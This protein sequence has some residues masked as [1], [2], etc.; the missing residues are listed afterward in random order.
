[1]KYKKKCRKPFLAQVEDERGRR[2]FWTRSQ[3]KEILGY[4]SRKNRRTRKTDPMP[5]ATFKRR[6]AL[7]EEEC[8]ECDRV[9][10]TRKF[11]D[12]QKWCLVQ[13]ELIFVIQCDRDI[14]KTRHYL[15]NIGLSTDDYD[16]KS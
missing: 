3:I 1:M 15:Q 4:V 2:N 16:F 14:E 9:L 12:F 8:P 11:S 7:L 6:L 5:E 10:H 13:L